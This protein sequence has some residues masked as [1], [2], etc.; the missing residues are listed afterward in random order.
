MYRR[1]KTFEPQPEVKVQLGESVN[2]TDKAKLS[3]YKKSQNSGISVDILEEV[4]RRGYSIWNEEFGQNPE[5]FAFDRV[6]SFIAGGFAMDLDE[7]LAKAC[8]KGY[9]AVGMKKKSG[10]LVPNCVPKEEY[11]GSEKVSSN[12]DDPSSRFDG[13]ASGA[14]VYAK[15]TPGQSPLPHHKD[16]SKL[17]IIKKVV[18]EALEELDEVAAW[19]RKEGKNPSGGLNKKGI[20]SYRREH[21]GSKLSMAVTTP[22]SK[23]KPGSKAA[24][25]RKSFC[26]RMGGMKGP[27]KDEHGKPTRKALS[28]R[29]WNCE[30]IEVNELSTPQGTTG[31]RKTLSSPMVAIRMASGKIEK[32]PPGKS[33]SS[34][35]G[36][37]E[38]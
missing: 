24:N 38:E 2:L 32:H 34:G 12:P 26:A 29:K 19:Q 17:S 10:K 11:T 6:N 16:K 13:T 14:A 20:A 33:G 9:K 35:G 4:Y 23:L 21:P 8:W 37:D 18:K 22:P 3:L 36:G 1:F 30:E 25:R 28:L 27:M 5:Q 15:D 31:K 7:D